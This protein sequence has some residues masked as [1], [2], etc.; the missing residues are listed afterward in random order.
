MHQLE[1]L[2]SRTLFAGVTII[3]HG[4][5][6]DTTGWVSTMADAIADRAGGRS[7]VAIYT[8]E[9]EADNNGNLE[10]A[11]FIHQSNT[12]TVTTAS[13]GETIIKLDWSSVSL[14]NYSTIQVGD[15]V[16]QWL[17]APSDGLPAL[18]EMPIHL[19]G[20]SRGASLNTEIAKDLGEQDIW[21]DQFTSLDPHPVN[22]GAANDGANFGDEPMITWS[23][24]VFADDYWRTSTSADPSDPSG[25]AVAGAFNQSLTASV[26]ADFSGS[27]HDAVYAWYY[28]TVDLK[29]ATDSDGITIPSA[30][31]GHTSALP[32][33]DD[34]GFAYSLI[35]GG[36]RP[37]SGIG[38]AFG[39]TGARTDP[40]ESGTQWASIDDISLATTSVAP[41][42]SFKIKFLDEDR[43]SASKIVFYLDKDQNPY[44][45]DTVRVL[46]D[47]DF[48]QN[49]AVTAAELKAGTTGV[50]RGKYY[51]YARI[52]TAG[53]QTRY[54]YAQQVLTIT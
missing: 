34:T 43:A 49:T 32:A 28:G 52:T 38:T 41:G 20:H 13:S 17:T 10:I 50:A 40:G 31:Y 51:V 8:L 54:A 6:D 33:R 42:H 24:T 47:H 45:G 3:T 39:G 23:N 26:Q 48:A 21:V 14:G 36:T 15:V 1:S 12:A 37:A 16:A 44:D 46:A 11:G 27:A 2:E 19:I 7:A 29:A 18:D 22:G 30:W 4:Y 35:A 5:D 9:V 25:E 53:G